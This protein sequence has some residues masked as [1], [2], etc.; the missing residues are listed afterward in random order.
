ML[1]LPLWFE[2]SV[3]A[4]LKFAVPQAMKNS[5]KRQLTIFTLYIHWDDVNSTF[6]ILGPRYIAVF[7]GPHS[8]H[9]YMTVLFTTFL[10]PAFGPL[11]LGCQN[12]HHYV[13]HR[14]PYSL[15]L[16]RLNDLALNKFGLGTEENYATC[17][18]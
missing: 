5:K 18:W 4:A 7:L 10:A 14:L 15:L 12:H 2:N 9:P 11:P 13:H 16:D 6:Y 1:S 17:A 3:L 8:S